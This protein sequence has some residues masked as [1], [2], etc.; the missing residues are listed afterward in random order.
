MIV[1]RETLLDAIYLSTL[2][3]ETGGGKG[4]RNAHGGGEEAL[5]QVARKTQ[6]KS[7]ETPKQASKSQKQKAKD[8]L[9]SLF[10][11]C[12]SSVLFPMHRFR[13]ID[14]VCGVLEQYA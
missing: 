14:C 1:K 10:A 4:K 8:T 7:K 2:E 3:R 11:V 9:A 12:L 6:N 5:K 13:K